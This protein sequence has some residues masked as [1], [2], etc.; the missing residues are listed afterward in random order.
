M[1]REQTRQFVIDR[2]QQGDEAS[3]EEIVTAIEGGPP[4]L[5]AEQDRSDFLYHAHRF[6]EERSD[7]YDDGLSEQV[8]ALEKSLIKQA[9]NLDYAARYRVLSQVADQVLGTPEQRAIREMDAQRRQG[10]GE[11][12]R[13]YAVPAQEPQS[14][15][16][17]EHDAGVAESMQELI[18]GRAGTRLSDIRGKTRTNDT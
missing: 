1:S 7:L 10:R 12:L 5:T 18:K 15:F 9:P 6:K 16:D 14:E 11:Q 2:A 8:N 13:E 17:T 4:P 3:I